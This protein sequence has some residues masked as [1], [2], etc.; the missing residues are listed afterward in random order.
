MTIRS[1]RFSLAA[2]MGLG[3][4]SLALP[5]SAL[6]A[7][8]IAQES[9]PSLNEESAE[10]ADGA[11]PAEEAAPV[12]ET[13]PPLS[14]VGKWDGTGGY[15]ECRN[16]FI[17]FRE[18]GTLRKVVKD[19]AGN[20]RLATDFQRLAY[21]REGDRLTVTGTSLDGRYTLTVVEELTRH[22]TSWTR[23][24]ISRVMEGP[25]GRDEQESSD[26]TRE[27]AP[28][29]AENVAGVEEA[30]EG[31]YEANRAK[32]EEQAALLEDHPRAAA[33]RGL[34]LKGM[35]EAHGLKINGI[36]VGQLAPSIDL[37]L[38][39]TEDG[40]RLAVA[41]LGN[42]ITLEQ[43][44]L[45]FSFPAEDT[46]AIRLDIKPK[47]IAEVEAALAAPDGPSK[48]L[49]L[50]LER[51]SGVWHRDWYGFIDL[52][53]S[54]KDIAAYEGGEKMLTL[55]QFLAW[56]DSKDEKE[57]WETL[58]ADIG[59]AIKGLEIF[60]PPHEDLDYLSLDEAS[61]NLIA[62]DLNLPPYITLLAGSDA[63]SKR[64]IQ[65]FVMGIAN[66]VAR[67]ALH[68]ILAGLQR[69]FTDV[70]LDIAASGLKAVQEKEQEPTQ[71][72]SLVETGLSYAVTGLDRPL[73]SA[74]AHFFLE[75]LVLPSELLEDL[76]PEEQKLFQ[77]ISVAYDNRS[78][79]FPLKAI[80]D[81]ALFVMKQDQEALFL[82]MFT[83]VMKIIYQALDARTEMW[84]HIQVKTSGFLV[85]M[86]GNSRYDPVAAYLMTATAA[87][88]SAGLDKV[89]N[90]L[91]EDPEYWEAVS[92]LDTA[93]EMGVPDNINNE[94]LL[95]RFS[96]DRAGNTLINDMNARP[97]F[98]QL[99]RLIDR[100]GI[101]A[102]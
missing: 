25:N 40:Y 48:A 14:L 31:Q 62:K 49:A 18:D 102:Q 54:V 85:D 28:C 16:S 33:L 78:D 86:E 94:M 2:L 90:I 87:I 80:W 19:S 30:L 38:I 72:L 27:L 100:E 39:V 91:R 77:K 82:T 96:L 36:E 75:D 76:S 22:D 59:T 89:V 73:S 44:A 57:E 88:R 92:F 41:S 79:G 52:D 101:L 66:P 71:T 98:N 61:I 11:A 26:I 17:E 53:V 58:D 1:S 69:P 5:G 83:S 24:P 47:T 56:V 34:L 4:L 67:K 84:E 9:Q 93:I 3:C 6:A 81:E 97:L 63:L 21:S 43:V 29:P 95:H 68:G 74:E 46:I 99:I 35:K 32:A 13:A 23:E 60:P 8:Q 10:A 64:E 37:P 12:E 50:T 51:F 15:G 20:W 70:S 42:T 45:D 65:H 55:D 7:S